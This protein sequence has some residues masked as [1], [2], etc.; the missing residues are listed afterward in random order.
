MSAEVWPE[1]GTGASQAPSEATHNI[2]RIPIL[3]IE[4]SILE[5]NIEA[6]IIRMG[7]RGILYHEYKK[8]PPHNS[9]I[10][11]I[12]APA[13]GLVGLGIGFRALRCRV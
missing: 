7:T 5:F 6:L 10:G 11:I 12:K 3:F 13:L 9:M 4:A 1:Q 2:P 8:E